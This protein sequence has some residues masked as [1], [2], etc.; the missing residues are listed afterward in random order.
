M[1][2][3]PIRVA[4][5]GNPNAGKTSLFNAL[6]GSNQ[7]VGNY[8]G[9]TVEKVS[10]TVTVGDQRLECDD[11]P[12][13]YSSN[14]V[15]EDE[16]VAWNAIEGPP[17]PDVLVYVL[18]VT[19]LER[20]LFFLTQL[21]EK[22]PRLVVAVTM[23][24]ALGRSGA[25]YDRAVLSEMLG[26]PVVPVI[27][28]KNVGVTELLQAI[29]AVAA[30]PPA[31]NSVPLNLTLA[32]RYE[33]SSGVR[34]A[35]ITPAP[36]PATS[37][38]KRI[39]RILT[40]RFFGLLIFVAIMYLV[41]QSIYTFAAPLQGWIEAGFAWLGGVVSGWTSGNPLLQS[42]LVDG[43]I[44]GIGGVL[45]FLPQIIILFALIAALEGSGYLARAAFLMDK[46]LGWC[47]LS[48]RAFVPLLSSFA[49]AIPG[50]MA[51]RVMPDPKSRLATILVAPLMSCSARLPVYVLLIGAVIQPQFGAAWAGFTLFAMHL[52]GLLVAIPVVL[53]LNR[54]VLK[55]K[56]LPFVLEL[57]RYQWP[58]LRDVW[59][60]MYSRAKV[61]L[62]TAGTVIVAMSILIWAASYF[63]RPDAFEGEWKSRY[64]SEP[65]SV[66]ESVSEEAYLAG[67]A[68][69]NSYLGRFGRAIEPAFR[70]IGFD[71]RLSTAIVAAFP[72]RE[73]VVPSMGIIF[74]Q[75][76]DTDETSAS[77]RETLK[78]AQLPDGKPLFTPA[79]AIGFMVFFALCCQCMST[80]AA[81]KRETNSWK[82]P[83]FMFVY[84]TALAYLGAWIVQLFS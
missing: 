58:K 59:I 31:K 5:V 36:K 42:L 45:V 20:H 76:A 55:G 27:A 57:P 46:L 15:S 40:H 11:I 6:T 79:T 75:G 28:H 33:Y 32:E 80:L 22:N 70:P 18:D 49:C 61:F 72:A 50:V 19:N 73:V 62:T 82:W 23:T 29:V 14:A 63:P 17:A 51:A 66:R 67:R 21:A 1:A 52:L 10:A 41:F 3:D 9:V 37:T 54:G 4:F 71:W 24:D 77:L 65:A 69:E 13:L 39:D 25:K 83:V 35:V 8:P 7:R 38:T 78:D 64:A 81:V 16:L 53:A 34:K 48:G 43:L 2:T 60:S 47:G 30:E 84:M 56:R 12:G 68:A 44:A 26:F 74:N